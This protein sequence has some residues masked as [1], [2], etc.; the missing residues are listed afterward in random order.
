MSCSD[1]IIISGHGLPGG[2]SLCDIVLNVLA[3]F[4]VVLY[5]VETKGKS[6]EEINNILHSFICNNTCYILEDCGQLN[7]RC[8]TCWRFN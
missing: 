2:H 6:I 8:I 4:F 3:V 1:T 7:V 5:V